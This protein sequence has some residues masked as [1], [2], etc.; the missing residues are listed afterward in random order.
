[1]HIF[2]TRY[3][4]NCVILNR[5]YPH[6]LSEVILQTWKYRVYMFQL[7]NIYKTFTAYIKVHKL[8]AYN[9]TLTEGS[10]REVYWIHLAR[11]SSRPSVLPSVSRRHDFRSVSQVCFGISIANLMCILIVVVSRNKSIDFQI[12]HFQDGRLKTILNFVVPD[13]HFS[14]A[15]NT[16]FKHQ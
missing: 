14:L 1:M 6:W 5:K 13:Y 7:S 15:F 3:I 12:G 8:L 4:G 16:N 11:P 9:H 10:C 2:S